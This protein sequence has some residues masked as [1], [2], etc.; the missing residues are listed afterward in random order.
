MEKILNMI[1][2][3]KRSLNHLLK[4][5]HLWRHTNLQTHFFLCLYIH[6]F[7]I[8]RYLSLFSQPG[9]TTLNFFETLTSRVWSAAINLLYILFFSTRKAE[10]TEFYLHIILVL[11]LNFRVFHYLFT[12]IWFF[13]II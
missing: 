10:K 13:V 9:L 7:S 3:R 8:C 12:N 1:L 11:E 2:Y 6:T 5:W 4:I